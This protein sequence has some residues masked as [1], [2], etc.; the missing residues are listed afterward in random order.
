MFIV[1]HDGNREL[2]I[3]VDF[4]SSKL[5]PIFAGNQNKLCLI[6]ILNLKAFSK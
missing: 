5:T 2:G 6:S 1:R 4:W 3:I